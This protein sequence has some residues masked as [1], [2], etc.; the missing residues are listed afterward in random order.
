[1]VCEMVGTRGNTLTSPESATE[2]HMR[3]FHEITSCHAKSQILLAAWPLSSSLWHPTTNRSVHP[4]VTGDTPSSSPECALYVHVW[5]LRK[6]LKT[7]H[8]VVLR[9]HHPIYLLARRLLY[10]PSTTRH[11]RTE[12][13]PKVHPTDH[14]TSTDA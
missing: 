13:R 2:L 3:H 8:V 4:H 7:G 9:V 6:T 1:M 11:L 10:V 12:L 14:P 5:F